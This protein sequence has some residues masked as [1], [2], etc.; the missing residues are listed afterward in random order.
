VDLADIHPSRLPF[1]QDVHYNLHVKGSSYR[2]KLWERFGLKIVDWISIGIYKSCRIQI[3]GFHHPQSVHRES[4]PVVYGIW[5]GHQFPLLPFMRC[6]G[7][8]AIISQS[9]DGELI[10]HL[11]SGW[12][13]KTYRG[14]S[15][16]GA[17]AGLVG[18][19]QHVRHGGDGAV[20]VDGPRGPIHEPKPGI[21]TVCRKTGAALIPMA[22]RGSGLIRL[23]SWDRFAV[24]KPFSSY[25]I[26]FGPPLNLEMDDGINAENLKNALLSLA[27]EG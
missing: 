4:R 9:R 21:F 7:I 2:L 8:G 15:S 22:A 11:V 1:P 6:Q 14:S 27:P 16:R 13:Y 5:H 3:E 23:K 20:T 24:L 26:V 19:I 12:G 25:T 17:V 18:L 10:A